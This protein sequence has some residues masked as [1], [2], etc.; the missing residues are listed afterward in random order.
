MQLEVRQAESGSED[1]EKIAELDKKMMDAGWENDSKKAWAAWTEFAT[2]FV[3]EDEK[4]G[5]KGALAAFKSSEGHSYALHK[6]FVEE[7]IRN[8]GIGST[9]LCAINVW[10]NDVNANCFAAVDIENEK[11]IRLFKKAGFNKTENDCQGVVGFVRKLY[12]NAGE[13]GQ[14]QAVIMPVTL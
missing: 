10:L 1:F 8:I 9:L 13:G 7:G 5:I 2:V 4:G 14:A 11:A 12:E 6:V 3:V